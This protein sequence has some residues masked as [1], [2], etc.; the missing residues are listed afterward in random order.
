MIRFEEINTILENYKEE[1][2]K[3][4]TELETKR[5]T[6]FTYEN[7]DGSSPESIVHWIKELQEHVDSRRTQKQTQEL[8]RQIL[9]RSTMPLKTFYQSIIDNDEK[10]A[11]MQILIKTEAFILKTDYE[12]AKEYF[13]LG[14][15]MEQDKTKHLENII[16]KAID[17]KIEMVSSADYQNDK[18]VIDKEKYRT[19]N[20]RMILEEYLGTISIMKKTEKDKVIFPIQTLLQS[21]DSEFL[22]DYDEDDYDLFMFSLAYTPSRITILKRIFE[23]EKYNGD[24]VSI[25]RDFANDLLDPK[26]YEVDFQTKKTLEEKLGAVKAFLKFCTN[27]KRNYLDTNI[28]ETD[29]PDLK[30]KY[31]NMYFDDIAKESLTRTPFRQEELVNMFEKMIDNNFYKSKNIANFYIPMIGLFS[32][33]R[34]EEICKLKTED[35]VIEDKIYCFSVTPPAKTK[36]SIRKIPIHSY[37]IDGLDFLQYV[38]SRANCEYLFDL[39]R[40]ETKGKIKHSHEYGQDF[41]AFKMDII[42]EKRIEEDLVSFHSFRHSFAT[43]LNAGRVSDNNISKL[44]GHIVKKTNETGRY[45]HPEYSMLKEDVELMNIKDLKLQL[46]SL[47]VKFKRS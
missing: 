3:E 41:G 31:T 16:K 1:A 36:S 4:Y 32:G 13:D 37:L 17:E 24:L 21:S 23:S 30:H 9:K 15:H 8:V 25:A 45:N 44:M 39:K 6:H 14:Y 47:S 29:D 42:S 20:K 18:S 35:I 34:I 7:R 40:V 22:I 11:F 43:R 19:K 5:H 2:L 28:L 46:K 38:K 12:R 26:G 10:T 27:P 33:M